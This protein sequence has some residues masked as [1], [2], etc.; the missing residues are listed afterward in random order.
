MMSPAAAQVIRCA[1]S[2]VALLRATGEYCDSREPQA[3]GSAVT[4]S[5]QPAMKS[6]NRLPRVRAFHRLARFFAAGIL[7][8][9]PGFGPR[10]LAAQGTATVAGRITDRQSGQ[11]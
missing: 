11:P 9:S 10:V 2:L 3:R 5:Q 8:V 4:P 1:P 6:I 7:A